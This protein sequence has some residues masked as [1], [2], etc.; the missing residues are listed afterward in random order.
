MESYFSSKEER[1]DSNDR[2]DKCVFPQRPLEMQKK[3]DFN[4]KA[5]A[6]IEQQKSET[7]L[8]HVLFNRVF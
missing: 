4:L 3:K 6:N 1:H 8:V 5:S 2:E 7:E